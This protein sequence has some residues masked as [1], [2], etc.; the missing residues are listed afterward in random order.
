MTIN[1]LLECH[2][3][4]AIEISDSA[5]DIRAVHIDDGGNVTIRIRCFGRQFRGIIEHYVQKF[6]TIYVLLWPIEFLFVYNGI[7]VLAER[8]SGS[9]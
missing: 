5:D 2:H 4:Y 1:F 7:C 3:R 6:C 9:R 8:S